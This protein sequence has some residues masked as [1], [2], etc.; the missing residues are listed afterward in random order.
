MRGWSRRSQRDSPAAI[1]TAFT[2]T[3]DT[4]ITDEKRIAGLDELEPTTN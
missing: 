4:H 1:D 2:S 3:P